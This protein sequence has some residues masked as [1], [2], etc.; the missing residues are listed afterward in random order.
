MRGTLF[1]AGRILP[2]LWSDYRWPVGRYLG[3]YLQDCLLSGITCIVDQIFCALPVF[4]SAG[5]SPSV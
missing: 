4:P 5:L 1:S 3:Q 2:G